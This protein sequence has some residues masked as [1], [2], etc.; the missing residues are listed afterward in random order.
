LAAYSAFSLFLQILTASVALVVGLLIFWRRRGDWS[1]LATSLLLVTLP[2]SN[3]AQSWATAEPAWTV[4]LQVLGWVTASCLPAVFYTFPSGRFVPRWTRWLAVAW[5]VLMAFDNFWPGLLQRVVGE[6]ALGLFF[7]GFFASF[8]LA[9][10]VRYHWLS[11]DTER[12]QIKWVVF[13]AALGMGVFVLF[14]LAVNL[15]EPRGGLWALLPAARPLAD[16]FFMAL[17]A[18]SLGI[19]ILRYRLWDIDV[20]I[21]RALVYGVLTLALSAFYFGSV[22]VLQS[23]LRLVSGANTTLASVASTLLLA[24]LFRPLRARV[25]TAIDRR[26]Y[27]RKYNAGQVL[28]AFGVVLRGETYA[29]IDQATESLLGVVAETLQPSHVSLWLPPAQRP[30]EK[31]HSP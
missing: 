6:E 21:N 31:A 24:A 30:A 9:L 11:N 3:L 23:G 7:A 22:L 28:T 26:F 14:T 17:L 18:L 1:A 12:Q 13:A 29:D 5:V 16:F 10:V 4:P 2:Q 8:A 19:A 25:Q 15:A 27:R 20:I